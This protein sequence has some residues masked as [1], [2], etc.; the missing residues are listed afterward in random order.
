MLNAQNTMHSIIRNIS[1]VIIGKQEAV[2]LT[3]LSLLCQGHVLVEDVPGVGKTSLVSALSK[4]VDCTFQRI[5]FTPDIMPSDITGFTM[6]NQKTGQ[7]D[8]K[9]GLVMSS[10]IL[11][12]EINRTSPKTQASLLEVMEEGQVTVDGT[13]YPMSRPF[14][15]L[16][17]QNPTEYLGTYPLPEAQMDRFLMRISLGYPE[18]ADEVHI[19]SRFRTEDPLRNLQPV[20]ADEHIVA[21]QKMTAAVDIDES[22]QSYAV[23]I[24]RFTRGHPDVGLGASPRGSLGLM[25]AAQ[26]RALYEGRGYVLPDDIKKMAPPVLTHRLILTQEARLRAVQ[27]GHIIASA[28]ERIPCPVF[29]AHGR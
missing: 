11:A 9:P 27:P 1:R 28:L 15:V 4:S 6:Y 19:L 3:L 26:A 2:V 25:R 16:A 13:T 22:L 14:M 5:Q 29:R 21:L 20:V 23:D 12:D 18:R 24:V 17:T 8:F 10:F 7:F